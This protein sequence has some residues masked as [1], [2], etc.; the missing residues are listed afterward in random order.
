MS[1]EEKDFYAK[2]ISE[3]MGENPDAKNFNFNTFINAA[4]KKYYPPAIQ[5]FLIDVFTRNESVEVNLEKIRALKKQPG[6]SGYDIEE[7]NKFESVLKASN[8]YWPEN[9]TPNSRCCARCQVMI[10][11]F[12]GEMFGHIG[13]VGYSVLVNYI[14]DTYHNGGCM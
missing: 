13:S 7:L 6:L 14:Q 12:A 4:A 9:Q 2:R 3:I 11:D 8:E 10:A 5:G 1:K